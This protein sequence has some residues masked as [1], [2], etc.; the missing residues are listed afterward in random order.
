MKK[1]GMLILSG[2]VALSLIGLMAGVVF[3]VSRLFGH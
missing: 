2:L 3:V 1:L